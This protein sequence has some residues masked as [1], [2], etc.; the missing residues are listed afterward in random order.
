MVFETLVF[1]P[2]NHLTRLIA[3]ENFIILKYVYDLSQYNISYAKLQWFISITIRHKAKYKSQAAD[4]LFY[5]L[6][7]D[8]IVLEDLSPHI[9]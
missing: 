8:C 5:I 6:Q 7:K 3:R 9:I 4:I 1:S 2:L